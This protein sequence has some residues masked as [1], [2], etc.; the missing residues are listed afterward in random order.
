MLVIMQGC[1]I[2]SC[3]DL[4]IVSTK[5]DKELRNK[6]TW[7]DLSRFPESAFKNDVFPHPGGPNRRVILQW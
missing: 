3:C 2:T 4:F 7:R 6:E 1:S 5:L